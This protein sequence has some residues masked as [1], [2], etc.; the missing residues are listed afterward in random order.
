MLNLFNWIKLDLEKKKRRKLSKVWGSLRSKTLQRTF[1]SEFNDNEVDRETFSKFIEGKIYQEI[2][3]VYGSCVRSGT[4][5][6]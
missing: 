5:N 6:K 1:F 3:D 4:G 2:E